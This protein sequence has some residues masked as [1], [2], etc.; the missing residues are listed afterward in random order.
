MMMHNM[1]CV[2]LTLRFLLLALDTVVDSIMMAQSMKSNRI[3]FYAFVGI[4]VFAALFWLH[5]VKKAK[6][7]A[8]RSVVK[9]QLRYLAEVF[10]GYEKKFS[11]PIII[12]ASERNISWR[13]LACMYV[14]TG[15]NFD[16]EVSV[17]TRAMLVESQVSDSQTDFSCIESKCVSCIHLVL[18]HGKKGPDYFFAYLPS[19]RVYWKSKETLSERDLQDI[20]SENDCNVYFYNSNGQEVF[21]KEEQA[22]FQLIPYTAE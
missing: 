7:I 6:E 18:F 11:H 13:T 4:V 17:A 22:G 20:L 9:G 19:V 2:L 8:K 1:H 15:S 5:G 3:V 21:Y 12:D 10:K 16:Q 14:E